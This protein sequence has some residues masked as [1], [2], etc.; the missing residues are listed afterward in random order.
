MSFDIY[1]PSF[2]IWKKKKL[3][4]DILLPTRGKTHTIQTRSLRAAVAAVADVR[5]EEGKPENQIK[6]KKS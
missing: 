5:A 1:R 4:I 3:L 2:G 6:K